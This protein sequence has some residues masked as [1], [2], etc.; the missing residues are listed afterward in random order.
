MSEVAIRFDD[1]GK[2]YKIFRS[3][4]D[5][6]LDAL[7]MTQFVLR[8]PRAHGEFWALRGVSF[9][10]GRGERLGIIG[11]NGAGKSTLLRLVT[12]NVPASEGKVEVRGDV[13]AL[14]EIG[15][16]LH[17]EFTGYENIRASLASMGANRDQIDAAVEDIAEFTEL[18]RFLDQPFKTYSLG[19]QARLSVGIATTM[20]PEILIIDEILGA[21]DAYFFAKST[22]RMERLLGDGASVLLVSHALDQVAR[23]C[24]ET[25]WI[26][27]GR[28]VMQG[29]TNE[30]IKAYEKFI[31]EL[32]DRRLRAKNSKARVDKFDA[33]E[34]DTYTATL[35]ARVH[36]QSE[37]VDVRLLHLY[38]DGEREET[39]AVGA[40]QDADPSQAAFVDVESGGW[41]AVSAGDGGYFRSVRAGEIGSALLYLWFFYPSSTYTLELEYRS[42]SGGMLTLGREGEQLAQTKLAPS[43]QWQSARL[44]L[45]TLPDH[46]EDT[47]KGQTPRSR[48]RWSGEESLAISDVRLLD[49][50]GQEQAVFDVGRPFAIE[51]DIAARAAGTFPVIPAALI[52][53]ADGIVVTR[54][55]GDEAI[56]G[57]RDGDRFNARLD[58]GPLW[59]GN[60][61]YLVS[62][63]LYSHLDIDDVQPSHF[64]DYFDK[65]FEFKVVGN[66]RLH[67]ELVRHPGSWNV[68]MVAPQEAPFATE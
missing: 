20:S 65:S 59:L 8:H 11:R 57:V 63:G 64:Y 12:G 45:R 1:V 41:S 3:R 21:G 67:N 17:P 39:V 7:G 23:F 40:A 66:P 19:M 5:N 30:V 36:A 44:E 61:A 13:Q 6:L 53:R 24:D 16:G 22:A 49:D 35:V 2:M 60:G 18:G 38:R 62:V 27:R 43:H 55:V 42:R 52:F 34:R 51:L 25:L 50:F 29:E 28:I 68:S 54:H 9:E 37:D 10:L 47:E 33:F 58:L 31:R 4:R 56:I 26:D 46:S 15:G 14:L 48:S 32:D